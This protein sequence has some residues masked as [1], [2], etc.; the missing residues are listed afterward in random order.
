MAAG[1]TCGAAKHQGH[2]QSDR[3]ADPTPAHRHD[4]AAAV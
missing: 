4:K 2:Q 3:H 1:K